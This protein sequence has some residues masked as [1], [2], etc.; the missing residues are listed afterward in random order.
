MDLRD[1]G[2]E[3]L[4][5]QLSFTSCIS[6]RGGLDFDDWAPKPSYRMIIEFDDA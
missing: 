1:I 5:A 3:M 4:N 6:H 2:H